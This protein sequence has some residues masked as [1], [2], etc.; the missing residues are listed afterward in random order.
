MEAAGKLSMLAV[1]NSL[2]SDQGTASSCD[3]GA[4]LRT[5]KYRGMCRQ[6][7]FRCGLHEVDFPQALTNPQ[8]TWQ[9][10]RYF[11]FS[12]KLTS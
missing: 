6:N 9:H 4:E 8:P 3:N 2:R 11:M 1:G 5:G 10:T 12:F 7:D